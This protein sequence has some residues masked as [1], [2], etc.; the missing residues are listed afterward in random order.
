[1]EVCFLEAEKEKANVVI[2]AYRDEITYRFVT[3]AECSKLKTNILFL[4]DKANCIW[5]HKDYKYL[6]SPTTKF[7]ILEDQESLKEIITNWDKILD[8]RTGTTGAKYE[9]GL[10]FRYFRIGHNK[11]YK[12]VVGFRNWYYV[13]DK[14]G[15]FKTFD[16]KMARIEYNK[17]LELNLGDTYERDIPMCRRFAIETSETTQLNGDFRVCYFDI[18]TNACVDAVATPG[19]IIS[20]VTQDSFTEEV[21]FW[22]IDVNSETLLRDEH[23]MLTEVLTYMRDHDV[24]SGW[25]IQRFDLPY[26]LNRAKLIGVDMRCCTLSGFE[27][28]CSHKESSLYPWYIN[29]PGM[30]VVDLM[31][32]SVRALAYL[33]EKLKDKKLDTVA[34]AILGETKIHTDT[35]AVLW[36]SGRMKELKEYN[37]Q[38]VELLMKIDRKLGSI[39][40]LVATIRL[41]P[42]LNLEDANYNSKIIDYYLI[43]NKKYCLPTVN[44][45]NVADI[46]GAIV[47][48]PVPGVHDDVAILDI[49]GMYP[50]LIITFNISPDTIVLDK[51]ECNKHIKIGPTTFSADFKGVLVEMV[52]HFLVLRK[53]YKKLKEDNEDHPDYE[54][55]KLQEFATKKILSSM[56]GVFGYR[57]FRFFDGRIA[58]AITESGR[59]LLNHM[60]NIAETSGFEVVA[61]DTD[62]VFIKNDAVQTVDEY[63]KVCDDM[64]ASLNKFVEGYTDSVEVVENNTLD[65]E[66]ETLFKKVIIAPAKKKYI[67]MVSMVKGKKVK[68]KLYYKGSELNKKDV[69]S[70]M[71]NAIRQIVMRVLT[72]EDIPLNIIREELLYWEK[73]VKN[74]P[75]NDLL[76]YKEINREFSKYKVMPQHVKAAINSNKYIGTNWSRQNYKGGVIYVKHPA[77]DIDALF[78][79]PG[80]D[81]KNT[82][83]EI[84]YDK[85]YTK[86]VEHKIDLIFGKKIY[87]AATQKNQLLTSFMETE[88]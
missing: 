64:N 48:D 7:I 10:I 20:V 29:I 51:S 1:M 87:D 71:K 31:T 62:S 49:S 33:D 38:D 47:F 19:E 12:V 27:P 52:Q 41:I 88:E 50:N 15:T 21:K 76:I 58:N 84:D 83:F 74:M 40:L 23:T 75:I 13:R 6:E 68:E 46:E 8:V 78:L 24:L 2:A 81:L 69:P 30:H 11:Y 79:Q 85:Y 39:E 9:A 73:E 44:R 86:F 59:D 70:G 82:R 53:H 34:E 55:Y 35:P 67:G 60:K 18:E 72:E 66:F 25:N 14:A 43:K 45:D 80:M 16:G 54:A 17:S 57:G 61:G 42:G 65:I 28:K 63:F 77:L 56:F 3:K 4:F 22:S 26:L 32:S 5:A 37:V 36:K